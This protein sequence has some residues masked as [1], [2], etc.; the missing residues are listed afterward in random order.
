M[1]K[2]SIMIDIDDPRAE[3]I[4][5]VLGNKTCKKIM[6]LLAEKDM[7]ESDIGKELEIPLNTVG[8][9]MKK[10]IESGL[11]EKKDFFWSVKGKKIPT[12]K[13]SNKR[14][15]ISPKSKIFGILPAIIA[16]AIISLGIKIY[17]NN[18]KLIEDSNLAMS[19][20]VSNIA[21]KSSEMFDSGVYYTLNNASNVWAWFLLG[22]LFGLLVFML[23]NWRNY[24]KK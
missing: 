23:W 16:S 13:I 12:Y 4:A 7:S 14:I 10:L 18:S 8:Y 5:D 3:N 22:A 1:N 2:H 17:Y 6:N 24:I 9:N 11:V 21:S 19:E 20:S 15:I